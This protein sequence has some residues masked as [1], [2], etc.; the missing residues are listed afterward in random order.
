MKYCEK[1]HTIIT[2]GE[3]C[4]CGSNKLSELKAQSG[5]KVADVKGSLRSIAEPALKE[6]GIPCEFF[7]PEKDIYTQYNPKVN[8]ETNYSLIV[9]FELYNEA[10]EV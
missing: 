8:R 6:K 1:C 9:P 10:F 2:E 7:N 5:V 4:T 3:T